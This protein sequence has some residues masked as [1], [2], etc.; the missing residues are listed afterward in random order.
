MIAG[1]IGIYWHILNCGIMSSDHMHACT[2]L[3]FRLQCIIEALYHHVI[4]L[5]ITLYG[6]SGHIFC[7]LESGCVSLQFCS[8]RNT[9]YNTNRGCCAWVKPTL[10]HIRTVKSINFWLLNDLEPR[11]CR[12]PP[13]RPHL[14]IDWVDFLDMVQNPQ[15]CCKERSYSIFILPPCLNAISIVFCTKKKKHWQN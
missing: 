10:S 11:W 8:S 15:I 9:Q 12:P 2:L 7:W 6:R 14:Q 4:A 13:P 1:Y 3:T 5:L